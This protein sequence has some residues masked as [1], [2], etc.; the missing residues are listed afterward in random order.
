MKPPNSLSDSDLKNYAEEHLQYE[1]EMLTWSAGIL[2]SLVQRKNLNPLPWAINNG[3][4]NTFAIHARNLTDFLYSRSK[5]K[6]SPTDIIIQDY[7]DMEDI[8]GHLI[9][10]SPILE[11]V[12]IKANKQVAHL[13]MERI[14]YEKLGKQWNFIEILRQIKGAFASITPYI[15]SQKMSKKLKEILSASSF[16]IPIIDIADT[17]LPNGRENGICFSP[18]FVKES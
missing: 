15:P 7:V 13:T 1:V 9:P 4:L 6:D 10:I 3:L 16:K 14:N 2:A 8:T 5:G 11:E 18:R 12:K 17:E